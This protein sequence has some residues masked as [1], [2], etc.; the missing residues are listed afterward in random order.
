MRMYSMPIGSRKGVAV[1]VRVM[2]G[3]GLGADVLVDVPVGTRVVRAGVGN[4]GG[5]GADKHPTRK[6]NE[7]T[8]KM[9]RFMFALQ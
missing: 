4:G 7:N 8:T 5:V 1:G 3:T 9:R 2:V 6:N